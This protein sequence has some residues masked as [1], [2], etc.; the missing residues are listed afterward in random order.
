VRIAAVDETVAV[1]VE[2]IRAIGLDASRRTSAASIDTRQTEGSARGACTIVIGAVFDSVAVVVG[3]VAALR[4]DGAPI[5]ALAG[6]GHAGPSNDAA[7]LTL[8]IRIGAVAAAVTVVVP[9]V[10]ALDPGLV[11][12][13]STE[14]RSDHDRE[15]R[16]G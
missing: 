14:R 1:V 8:A 10:P 16:T 12:A 6:A 3:S 15:D 13:R 7:A 4:F 2:P 5:E 11:A 9:I